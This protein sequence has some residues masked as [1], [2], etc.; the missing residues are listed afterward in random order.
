MN[1]FF[2]NFSESENE[3]I[4]NEN[5]SRHILKSYRKDI[6]EILN[7]TN[8]NGISII[9]EMYWW[10]KNIYDKRNNIDLINTFILKTEIIAKEWISKFLKLIFDGPKY[11]GPLIDGT[12]DLSFSNF[13]NAPEKLFQVDLSLIIFS[14]VDFGRQV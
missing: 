1:L 13:V 12:V 5:D 9:T 8:G 2:S 10:I 14:T 6:G 4:V 11:L 7:I 3:I